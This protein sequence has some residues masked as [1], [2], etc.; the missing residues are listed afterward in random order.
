MVT[1]TYFFKDTWLD[2]DNIPKPILDALKGLVLVEDSQVTDLL[3]RN[4]DRN[5]DLQFQNPSSLLAET[6][7]QSEQFLHI[8]VVDALSLEVS[9]W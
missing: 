3:C 7:G 1:I 9:P 6:L 4:R 8:T 5:R 2:V